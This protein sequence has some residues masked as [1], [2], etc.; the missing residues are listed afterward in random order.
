MDKPIFIIKANKT[1][2]TTS[3][4]NISTVPVLSELSSS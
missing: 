4:I 1:N 2:L 3:K